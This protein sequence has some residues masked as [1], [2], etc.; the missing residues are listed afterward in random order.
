M[1]REPKL[2]FFCGKMA[3]GKSTLARTLAEGEGTI[4]IE[5][6]A[7]L[8]RLYPGEIATLADFARCSRRLREALTPH[9]VQVLGMGLTVILDFPGNTRAQR[10]WFRELSETAGVPHELHYVDTH[11]DVCKRQLRTRS[12]HLP[13]G[14]PWTTEAEFE[15]VT[16][17]FEPPAPDEGFNVVRHEPRETSRLSS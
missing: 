7:W 12:A 8:D 14:T 10:A 16:A 5:Q 17:Y 11:D 15:A 1:R 13:P 9:V 3:A 4:L 2:V 6:D